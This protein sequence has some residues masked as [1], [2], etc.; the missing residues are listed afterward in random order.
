MVAVIVFS[1]FNFNIKGSGRTLT[2]KV[3]FHLF[4]I[5]D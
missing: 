2:P 5:K 4:L 3:V 1:Q